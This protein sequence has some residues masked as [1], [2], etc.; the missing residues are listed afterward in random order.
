MIFHAKFYI[1][2]SRYSMVIMVK[3]CL[4]IRNKCLF[5]LTPVTNPFPP[6]FSHSPNSPYSSP[7]SP[8]SSPN[9][10]YSS[11]NSPY[12]S[13]NS[14]YSSPNSPYSS[15]YP[16]Y[17]SPKASVETGLTSM[18][19]ETGLPGTESSTSRG[20]ARNT[21]NGSRLATTPMVNSSLI[22]AVSIFNQNGD[23]GHQ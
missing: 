13:P 3:Y 12:S 17:S 20:S 19:S 6:C 18:S 14:P 16:P 23:S 22:R 7:N 11:P 9:S 21:G 1:R 4:D 15:P 8:Y 2:R 5:P 10:P